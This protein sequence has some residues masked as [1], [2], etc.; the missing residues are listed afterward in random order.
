MIRVL[1]GEYLA[2]WEIIVVVALLSLKTA[3]FMSHYLIIVFLIK[4]NSF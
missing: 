4:W 1:S 3:Q 2:Q